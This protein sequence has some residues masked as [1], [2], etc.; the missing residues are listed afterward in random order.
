MKQPFDSVSLTARMCHAIFWAILGLWKEPTGR[1]LG[2]QR[3]LPSWRTWGVQ[4]T[5]PPCEGWSHR[6][7]HNYGQNFEIIFGM[8]A[9]VCWNLKKNDK[10]SNALLCRKNSAR[11]SPC[12][13]PFRSQPQ[14]PA[15]R[16]VSNRIM[17]F[18]SDKLI[19]P[20]ESAQVIHFLICFTWPLKALVH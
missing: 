7:C 13:S 9:K 20:P 3:I 12:S 11:E 6:D 14:P 18:D 10:K 17:M 8:R 15:P 1:F 2:G 19:I 4:P 5:V 16:S